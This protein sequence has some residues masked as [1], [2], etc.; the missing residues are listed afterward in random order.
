MKLKKLTSMVLAGTLCLS[1]GAVMTVE[2]KEKVKIEYWH[3]MSG[4][5]GEAMEAAVADFNETIGKEKGIEVESV[6]QGDD[7]SEKLKTLAQANDTKNFPNVAQIVGAGIPSTLGYEQLVKIED[8]YKSGEN[9]LVAKEDLNENAVRA[10]SYQDELIAMP[11]NVSSILLYYN[12]DMFEEVG[13]DPEN[14]PATIAEMADA[15]EKLMVK[16]GDDVTRYGLN[17][18]VRRYQL[19]NWIGGQGEYNFFGDNEGGRSDMMTKVTFGE[20]GSLDK[21]LTEWEKVIATGGYK[22][23]EDNI[24][25]EF[26]LQLFGMAVMSSARIGKINALVGENFEW[27]T[28]PLPKVDAADKGGTSVGGS[29]LAMY[30]KGNEDQVKASWEFVQYLATPEVQAKF[31]AATGYLPVN[32]KT[33]DTEE[34]KTYMEENPN[35][36]VA[37]DQMLSSNPNVQEPFDIINWELDEVIKNNMA[38]FGAGNQDKETTL[39]NI[40]DQCNERLSAYVR[41]NG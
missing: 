17:V 14:P 24:N 7:V 39:N 31:D 33:Y 8:M 35:Y 26:A 4:V 27:A 1:S 21:F 12:K 2:A 32:S 34:M 37:V 18:A 16:D 23:I 25:E 30:D 40:V 3:T 41:A 38:E 15:C 36:K 20:D 19:A 5:N 10:F 6:Y 11:F 13:L 22:E 9:I 29:C 28:A